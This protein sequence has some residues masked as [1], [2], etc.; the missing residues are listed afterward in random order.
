MPQDP[1]TPAVRPLPAAARRRLAA[2]IK[3]VLCVAAVYAA[4]RWRL[5]E[6]FL[7]LVQSLEGLGWVGMLGFIGLYIAACVLLVPGSIL[8]LGAGSVFGIAR[9]TLLVSVASTL[10]AICAFLVG[11]HLARDWVRRKLA[12]HPKFQAIDQA[13][14][15]EGWKVVGL[16]RLSPVF[17]FV[18]LNYAYGLTSVSL[19]DYWL[20]SWVGMLPG[21][22]LYV[23][24]G[25]LAHDVA[26]LA[27]P[28]S[29]GRT[30]L[31][32]TLYGIG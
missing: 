25:S 23:Y 12:S 7:Q 31:E 15:S 27:Q 29:E 18:L 20:A 21:T 3:I 8:T 2:F 13:V 10:G 32:W 11:R 28:R 4:R 17:P 9:G 19:R 22:I 6:H 1:P 26:S 30:P 5:S 24:L 14:A 16:T